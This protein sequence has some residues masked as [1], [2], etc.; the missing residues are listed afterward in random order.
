MV[1]SACP[2]VRVNDED[3]FYMGVWSG[4]HLSTRAD[5]EQRPYYSDRMRQGRIAL[6]TQKHNRYVSLR[7]GSQRETV[8]TRPF[9][10][11]ADTLELNVDATRGRVR[12]A[13]AEYKPVSSLT[14]NAGP[15]D[16]T[17]GAMSLAPHLLMEQNAL[18][19]F[20]FDDCQPILANSTE[21]TVPFRNGTSLASIRGKT[22]VLCVEMLDADLYG[23][24]LR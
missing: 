14:R 16:A 12:V 19:G 4:D 13:I 18:P 11:E 6:Y 7:T 17:R 15:S 24:R 1:L 21:F 22:V 2:P 8:I 20:G 5:A 9:K 23:F 3:W 10:L